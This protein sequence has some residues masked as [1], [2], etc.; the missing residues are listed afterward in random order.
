MPGH[1]RPGRQTRGMADALFPTAVPAEQGW[2]R[3]TTARQA[4]GDTGGVVVYGSELPTEADLKLLG[5]VEGARIL[6]LG[7]G[8]GRN[9]VVLAQSGAKVLGVDPSAEQL[10]A[11]LSE[12]L[13]RLPEVAEARVHL[14][15]PAPEPLSPLGTP[16]PTASVLLKLRA[17]LSIPP[18]EVAELIAH[19][20]PGLEVQ[21]V[22]VV[23]APAVPT[24]IAASPSAS[25]L[26]AVGP[27][28]VAAESRTL[29]IV[30]YGLLVALAALCVV[31]AR[32]A[33]PRRQPP[34]RP[35]SSGTSALR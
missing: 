12:T 17:A 24:E 31:L 19:A 5:T 20:V 27:M 28:V 10:A 8:T 4:P 21:D 22:A 11:S 30:L 34:A 16:R 25:P 33:W 14:A 13:E 2:H 6:D 1:A 9:A 32:L 23:R 7:C 18:G 15:L 29:V 35:L 3:Y 26:V